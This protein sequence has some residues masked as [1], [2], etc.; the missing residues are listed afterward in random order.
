M[1]QPQNEIPLR[2]SEFLDCNP[3]HTKDLAFTLELHC[4]SKIQDQGATGMKVAVWEDW[5][6]VSWETAP[7]QKTSKTLLSHKASS[8]LFQPEPLNTRA[9]E[10]LWNPLQEQNLSVHNS[11][12]TSCRLLLCLKT[13]PV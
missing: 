9:A 11:Q 13:E 2:A 12:Q 5:A 7:L 6:S 10:L 1:A 4:L 3:R 8:S